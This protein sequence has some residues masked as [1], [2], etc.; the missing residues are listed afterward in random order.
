MTAQLELETYQRLVSY[1]CGQVSLTEFRRWFDS[2]TWDQ[3][4]W[5]SPLIG[6]IELVL[7]ELSSCN[8]TKQEFDEALQS[9]IPTV[10]LE[11][12][13]ITR[14]SLPTLVTSGAS[15]TTRPLSA[16]NNARPKGDPGDLPV[17]HFLW[18]PMLAIS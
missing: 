2:N 8:L 7:A 4:Q 16:F 11:V 15:N 10:T 13:P 6:Q 17:T 5:E 14:S 9:S 12:K 1:L 3:G 18:R